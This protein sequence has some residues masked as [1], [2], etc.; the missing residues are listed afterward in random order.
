MLKRSISIWLV[1]AFC[2]GTGLVYAFDAAQLQTFKSTKVC[3]NCDFSFVNLGQTSLYRSNVP[4][5]N[6]SLAVIARCDAGYA[7]AV[8]ANFYGANLAEGKFL[9][10]NLTGANLS[11]AN[12]YRSYLGS[13]I[14]EG[15][16]LSNANLSRATLTNANL[17]GANLTGANLSGAIWVDG[18]ICKTPSIGTCIK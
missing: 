16:N 8:N 7:Y 13:A 5:T 1:A 12:L 18:T 10:A 6:F 17:T 2:L 11:G 3:A 9:G 15:A 14:L 4:N